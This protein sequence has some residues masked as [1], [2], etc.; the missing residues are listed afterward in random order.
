MNKSLL[1]LALIL[2]PWLMAGQTAEPSVLEAA[3]T[4]G[5]V[6]AVADSM[7][8]CYVFPD[9][10]LAMKK[11]LLENL[12]A[13]R[14]KALTLPK[15]AD[16]V[17]RDLLA[18]SKD[19]HLAVRLAGGP[20]PGGAGMPFEENLQPFTEV[21]ILP[22][23]VGYVR[24]DG[25]A[26]GEPALRGALG[27]MSL[28]SET[29]AL[30]FDMRYNGGG[31][32]ALIQVLCGILLDKPTLIN[33]VYLRPTDRTM[34]SWSAEIT[35]SAGFVVRNPETGLRDT[36]KTMGGYEKLQKIPVYVLT[37]SY[38]FSAAEEFTYNLQSLERAKIVGEVT[39]GG[40]HP[41]RPVRVPGGLSIKMPFARSINPVTNT[42]WEGTGIQ[43]NIPAKAGQALETAHLD[44]LQSLLATAGEGRKDGLLWE[45]E[46][47]QA[48]AQA[49]M[50]TEAD[51]KKFTGAYGDRTITLEN[52]RLHS[53]RADGPKFALTPLSS[54]LFR[55]DDNVRLQFQQDAGGQVTGVELL[56]KGRKGETQR[57]SLP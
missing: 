32:M 20:G 19:K 42:N 57:R 46:G 37:S 21:K 55:L 44:A 29:D 24:F 47:L 30:I 11:A 25:F 14:Y 41:V 15:L 52:G 54:L 5:I 36:L 12:S 34:E 33:K 13:G 35:H 50:P 56:R 10:G 3:E 23:N 16:V 40:A 1:F 38:T 7:E 43:P 45:I 51:L 53:Q 26:Q 9:K 48:A 17:S 18:L 4:A 6:N 8:A 27:A 28:V 49:V 2:L 39:G 31:G 22:G